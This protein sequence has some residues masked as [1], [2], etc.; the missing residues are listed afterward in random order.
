MTSGK[1]IGKHFLNIIKGEIDNVYIL[2]CGN[3]FLSPVTFDIYNVIRVNEKLSSFAQE[4]DFLIALQYSIYIVDS[5]EKK[6]FL[7]RLAYKSI[8][9]KIVENFFIKLGWIAGNKNNFDRWIFVQ[10]IPANV[11][12]VCVIQFDIREKQVGL[13]ANPKQLIGISKSKNLMRFPIV[14][15]QNC[16]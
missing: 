11:N 1:I 14:L 16:S 5:F 15:C 8:W 6:G 9:T 7:Y 10:K 13:S 12:A 2:L 3:K 4:L